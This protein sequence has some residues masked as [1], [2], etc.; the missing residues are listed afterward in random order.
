MRCVLSGWAGGRE[1]DSGD[2]QKLD[3]GFRSSIPH[4]QVYK[5]GISF[6]FLFLSFSF[7][8]MCQVLY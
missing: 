5:Q 1:G 4:R 8:L 6:F 3:G 7:L 2:N